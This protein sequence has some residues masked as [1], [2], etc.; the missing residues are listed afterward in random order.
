MWIQPMEQLQPDLELDWFEKLENKKNL[1]F[2]KFDLVS[3]FPSIKKIIFGYFF[4]RKEVLDHARK[5][6]LFQ[7]ICPSDIQLS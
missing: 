2:F 4:N 3:Y 5:S 7:K 6:Y 1:T